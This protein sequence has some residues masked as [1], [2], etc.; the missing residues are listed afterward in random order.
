MFTTSSFVG[1]FVYGFVYDY[2]GLV[3]DDHLV[4]A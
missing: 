3:D 1:G 4:Q 2:T